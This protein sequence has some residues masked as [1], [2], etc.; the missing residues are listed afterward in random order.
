[1]STAEAL[2]LGILQGLTE[3]LPVSSSG[4]LVL[5]REWLG[6]GEASGLVFEVL[7]HVATVLAIVVFF[8]RRI[9]ELLRGLLAG[10]PDAWRYAAKLVV[11]TLPAVVVG[12][13]FRHAIEEA[14]ASPTFAAAGLIVTGCLLFTTRT[15]LARAQQPEPDFRAALLIG[16]AQAFAIPPGISRSGTT[17]VVALALGV[18]PMA[19]AEFSF[20]L[21]VIAISGAAVLVLPDLA[22][23]V[24]IPRV[25]LAVGFAAAAFAGL[26]ALRSFV[27]LLERRA[28]Y[29]FA[30]YDWAVGGGCL[31]F[32]AL[33]G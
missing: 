11:A 28:F 5:A 17:V 16:I 14:F 8:R 23:G 26:V 33:R 15:S 4:H 1:M 24:A 12:G 7:L 27:W 22:A 21:G 2:W 13:F 30:Y 10:R 6:R 18:A 25:A 31:L 19:A 3:F 20:L 9:A 29:A 32:F